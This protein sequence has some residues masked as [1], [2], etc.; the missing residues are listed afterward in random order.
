MRFS[1]PYKAPTAWLLGIALSVIALV[2]FPP[3]VPSM[4]R[5][6]LD[7]SWAA[8][9]SH[10]YNKGW[11]FGNDI[12]F[13]FGPLGFVYSNLFNPQNYAVAIAVWS[14]IA[15][16]FAL[17]VTLLVSSL[18]LA[19]CAVILLSLLIAFRAGIVD[20][21]LFNDPV[22]FLVPLLLVL[23]CA[24]PNTGVARWLVPGLLALSALSGL[25]KFTFALLGIT[26]VLLLDAYRLI[27]HRRIPIYFPAYLLFAA[28]FFVA[29]GQRLADFPAY[30]AGSIAITQGYSEAM[31][32][33]G[34]PRWSLFTPEL[35]L[36]LLTCGTFLTMACYLELRRS[37]E[38][39]T[40][41]RI[42]ALIA[43]ALFL[44]IVFKAGFVRHDIHTLIAWSG[45]SA[46]IAVYSAHLLRAIA[47][48]PW[49]LVLL[50]FC[51]LSSALVLSRQSGLL[52]EPVSVHLSKKSA[53]SI[54]DRL[55]AAQALLLGDGLSQLR[56]RRE[57]ALERIRTA[58]P[59]SHIP[60]TVDIYPWDAAV[61]LAHGFE[62][63]PRPVFQS[64]TVYNESLASINRSH[65]H[66]ERAA[67]TLLFDMATID[68][69]FVAED[70][71]FG[72]PDILAWYDFRGFASVQHLRLQRRTNSRMTRWRPL[73]ASN[74]TW[75][76]PV[77][78]P[79]SEGLVWVQIALRHTLSGRLANILFKSPTIEF[80]LIL[81]D[82]TERHY[83]LVPGI[84]RQGFL[85][86][87]VVDS[88]ERFAS[89]FDKT[90]ALKDIGPRVMQLRINVP[91]PR[92][93]Q[94]VYADDIQVAFKA[95]SF[96]RNE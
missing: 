56:N 63:R 96:E 22:L 85:L 62:Y 50:L 94:W 52:G 58:H 95:F 26:T 84:A 4:P 38:S 44:F 34:E 25:I 15:V 14:V 70:E 47:G 92:R 45:L 93:L 91:E 68:G 69:R 73:A 67:S 72:W 54:V 18:R 42:V 90:R 29:A 7:P 51:A 10:A 8:V 21:A 60:G 49:R 16:I 12:V 32:I 3:W 71:G 41:V 39:G 78:V 35:V 77:T 64:F 74:T 6:G 31:Q 23:A 40:R 37:Q 81:D 82:G 55:R 65:L 30:I 61:I 75:S 17:S 1:R 33:F 13:T 20:S 76:Q 79:A 19:E 57:A 2:L 87:P 66:S 80:T 89:L 59:I 46:G 11:Q 48:V 28:L 5:A 83:R 43:L 36:F 27:L 53:V 9:L 24:H 88:V 86:S